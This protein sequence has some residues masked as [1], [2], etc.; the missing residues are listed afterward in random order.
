MAGAA[1]NAQG[2]G[3]RR[4]TVDRGIERRDRPVRFGGWH[5]LG[6][7]ITA[8]TNVLVRL[9]TAD[10]EAQSDIALETMESASLVAIS[11]HSLCELAWVLDRH[12]AVPRDE[13]AG[14]IRGLVEA[15]NVVVNRPAVDAG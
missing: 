2:E 1:W 5:G 7:K 12:Y 3:Q 6:M 14:A 11:V 8:D 10:D 13:I 4:T 15:S 9:V